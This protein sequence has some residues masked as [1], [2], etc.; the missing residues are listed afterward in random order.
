MT[1]VALH[2]LQRIALAKAVRDADTDSLVG[3]FDIDRTA[4]E[5]LSELGQQPVLLPVVESALWA[6]Q[7]L[8]EV[9]GGDYPDA[10]ELA[11]AL[12]PRGYSF[13]TEGCYYT[14]TQ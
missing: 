12:A 7:M 10:T 4:D 2:S 11:A 3:F 8:H 6:M 1:K 9:H 5:V 13:N 14:R